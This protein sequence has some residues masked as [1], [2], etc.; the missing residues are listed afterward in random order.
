MELP[1][2]LIRSICQL[3]TDKALCKFSQTCK[4]LNQIS[5]PELQIRK[6]Y[7][8]AMIKYGTRNRKYL[9]IIMKYK[10]I[11][12]EPVKF[13]YYRHVTLVNCILDSLNLNPKLMEIDVYLPGFRFIGTPENLRNYLSQMIKLTDS[14][15]EMAFS[16][17]ESMAS[18]V[19]KLTSLD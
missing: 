15:L 13:T 18:L 6:E 8:Q 2:E 1:I 3:L 17:C 12:T 10:Q 4:L 9:T 5:Q 16:R 7:H 19:K 14:Q 11:A